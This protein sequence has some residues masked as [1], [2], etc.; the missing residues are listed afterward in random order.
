M[1]EAI[2][3]EDMIGIFRLR[4]NGVYNNRKVNIRESLDNFDSIING[5]EG[6]NIQPDVKLIPRETSE[7]EVPVGA[8]LTSVTSKG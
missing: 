2:Q 7:R 1:K 3:L 8:S 5:I 6:N 4:K